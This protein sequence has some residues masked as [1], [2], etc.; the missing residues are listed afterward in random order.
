ML[1]YESRYIRE[2][3][4]SKFDQ[5][6]NLDSL[7][8]AMP[9]LYID[10]GGVCFGLS[11]EAAR[12]VLQDFPT[13]FEQNF[14]DVLN[15][16]WPSRLLE[17]GD[18]VSKNF[19]HRIFTYQ[20]SQTVDCFKMFFEIN[21][22]G[23]Y[24]L[25]NFQ[26]LANEIKKHGATSKVLHLTLQS[27]EGAHSIIIIVDNSNKE[28]RYRIFDPN[29]GYTG[30]LDWS[31]FE[32]VLNDYLKLVAHRGYYEVTI[33]DLAGNIEMLDILKR[34]QHYKKAFKLNGALDPKIG[35]EFL[36]N[37]VRNNEARFIILL[38]SYGY[39]TF[40][41]AVKLTKDQLKFLNDNYTAWLL[42]IQKKTNVYQML[43]GLDSQESRDRL[44][45]EVLGGFEVAFEEF[46]NLPQNIR[47]ILWEKRIG[48]ES[49]S[50]TKLVLIKRGL[51]E[52]VQSYD[53]LK[54]LKKLVS[55]KRGLL[56]IVQ[57]YDDLRVVE[58]Y[59]DHEGADSTAEESM[60]I[61]YKLLIQD[62][63]KERF[64]ARVEELEI[65][66]L[67]R[68]R[69]ICKIKNYEFL[70]NIDKEASLKL[71][72]IELSELGDFIDY[73]KLIMYCPQGKITYEEFKSLKAEKKKFLL[74]KSTINSYKKNLANPEDFLGLDE[75]KARLVCKPYILEL[76]ENIGLKLSDFITDNRTKDNLLVS[77]ETIYAISTKRIKL[78]SLKKLRSDLIYY[79]T[80]LDALYA[81]EY[82]NFDSAKFADFLT[83]NYLNRF[84]VQSFFYQEYLDLYRE[85]NAN[86][87]LKDH[88]FDI[89][90]HVMR[91]KRELT[92]RDFLNKFQN[93]ITTFSPTMLGA[94]FSPFCQALVE[95]QDN[96]KNSMKRDEVKELE[97]KIFSILRSP[98]AQTQQDM[99]RL[100][101]V[102][103]INLNLS[104]GAKISIDQLEKVDP[105]YLVKVVHYCIPIYREGFATFQEMS[106]LDINDLKL[107]HDNLEEFKNKSH[108][109][110]RG[111][112]EHIKRPKHD[113]IE[114]L[115]TLNQTS[116]TERFLAS[117]AN[118]FRT[119]SAVR[120]LNT[121]LAHHGFDSS[122]NKLQNNPAKQTKNNCIT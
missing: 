99:E 103:Y 7:K 8:H 17:Y 62:L 97:N 106:E 81:Y 56:E 4:L 117:V 78:D 52:V 46:K 90:L 116:L 66:D 74:K 63:N 31:N 1:H 69:M 51:L 34:S 121:N 72:Q 29:Y 120:I 14:V 15:R 64:G 40:E 70:K 100:L 42:L 13:R 65:E 35:K 104:N 24:N 89:I 86:A 22:L 98:T 20:C 58:R 82:Y 94:Y 10:Q 118:F 71:F 11:K 88:I 96:S 95:I 41:E 26:E 45:F 55:I 54:S 67:S 122:V 73:N 59:F 28:F 101:A 21:R 44:F 87:N 9:D 57:S 33:E 12:W 53:E 16:K 6:K 115:I 23:K 32:V 36:P 107:C 19:I 113:R 80:S 60:L 108:F 61:C 50:L 48:L 110:I 27:E 84:E 38:L 93:E 76:F 39:L 25:F 112:S 75:P 30:V 37:L 79:L 68:L 5:S 111:F 2:S 83:K 47:D 77:F 49:K 114:V 102:E 91:L 85:L 43:Q 18:N 109:T 119:I 92:K 3:R 105:D